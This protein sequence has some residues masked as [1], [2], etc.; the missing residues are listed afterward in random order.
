MV[1][2][3][4]KHKAWKQKWG[5]LLNLI[6]TNLNLG[7]SLITLLTHSPWERRKAVP[8][9]YTLGGGE[10]GEKWPLYPVGHRCPACRQTGPACLWA[11]IQGVSWVWKL[12]YP[13]HWWEEQANQAS[14]ASGK[15]VC[16]ASW[17]RSN[18][19]TVEACSLQRPLSAKVACA[20]LLSSQHSLDQ[21]IFSVL[22]GRPGRLCEV[23]STRKSYHW[24]WWWLLAPYLAE[25]QPRTSPHQDGEISHNVIRQSLSIQHLPKPHL[26]PLCTRLSL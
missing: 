13:S 22:W 14:N 18:Y 7:I 15:E 19:G 26:W 20:S 11:T 8:C 21:G 6:P 10:R 16:G 2:D 5:V 9:L 12:A 4:A 25:T 23:S 24:E 17:I 3:R 1:R